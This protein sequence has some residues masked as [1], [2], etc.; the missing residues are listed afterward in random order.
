MSSDA[1]AQSTGSIMSQPAADLAPPKDDPFTIEQL[2][3]FDGATLD[4]PIYVAIKGSL[5]LWSIT[6][7]DSFIT[8]R[9]RDSLRRFSEE[10]HI[11]TRMLIPLLYWQRC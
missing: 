10:K 11:W 5:Q 7:K 6:A 9:D 2:K 1:N 3:H 4:I 8:T